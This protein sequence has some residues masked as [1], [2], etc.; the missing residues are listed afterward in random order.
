LRGR[1]GWGLDFFLLCGAPIAIGSM[2]GRGVG[3][4]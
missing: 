4:N 1:P 2:T 3:G